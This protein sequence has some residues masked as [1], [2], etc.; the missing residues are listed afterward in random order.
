[1]STIK[2]SEEQLF[3]NTIV[4]YKLR[5]L[6]QSKN[7]EEDIHEHLVYLAGELGG[8]ELCFALPMTTNCNN[9]NC[10]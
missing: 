3:A 2:L 4:F 8:C 1:M 6:Q 9:A 10:T 7:I 5:E